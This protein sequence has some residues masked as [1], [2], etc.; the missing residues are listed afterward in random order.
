MNGDLRLGLKSFLI[1]ASVDHQCCLLSKQ[2]AQEAK[3][4]IQ[5]GQTDILFIAMCFELLHF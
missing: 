1:P 4:G 2:G 3:Q 5:K